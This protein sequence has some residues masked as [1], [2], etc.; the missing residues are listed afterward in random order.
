MPTSAV[1]RISGGRQSGVTL[2]E[3]VVVVTIIGLL[4]GISYPAISSG[5]DTIRL[6]SAS[7]SIVTLFNG[8][9]N[10]AER[11]QQAMEIV[12]SPKDRTITLESSEPGFER[13]V[14]LPD[15]VAIEAVLPQE[16]EDSN[17]PRRFLLLPG[18][19]PPRVGVQL[20]NRRGM[21]RIVRVD[22]I[23]GV[24]QVEI[25]ESK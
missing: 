6:R 8:A 3:M 4:A 22:P 23:T 2:I 15:G 25:P 18:G 24:P 16:V 5:L 17:A 1:G 7:D 13:R 11:R 19:T 14:T 10:R 12:I 21:R 20:A 9:L